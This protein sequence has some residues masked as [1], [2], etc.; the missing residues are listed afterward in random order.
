MGEKKTMGS[1]VRPAL[2]VLAALLPATATALDGLGAEQ[3][4]ALRS[5]LEGWIAARLGPSSALR[6]DLDGA[7]QVTAAGEG[8][9]VTLPPARL[10]LPGAAEADTQAEPGRRSIALD[11]IT[12]ELVPEAGGLWSVAW[13]LPET[14]AFTVDGS[15]RTIVTIE[16]QR[17]EGVY[18]AGLGTFIALDV[19]WHGVR[20]L[21][22][23]DSARGGSMDA[24]ALMV[25]LASTPHD[26]TDAAAPVRDAVLSATLRGFDFIDTG[27]ADAQPAASDR[28]QIGGMSV[29]LTAEALDIAA[30]FAL[31]ADP[32]LLGAAAPPMTGFE[33]AW[34]LDG[35]RQSETPGGVDGSA[36]TGT[37]GDTGLVID[38]ARFAV[39]IESREEGDG[40]A[41]F[42][43]GFSGIDNMGTLGADG[44]LIPTM[45]DLDMT[46]DGVPGTLAGRAFRALFVA[47]GED[48][49]D[50][51]FDLILSAAYKAVAGGGGRLSI[52]R[53]LVDFERI[54][55]GLSVAGLL[56]GAT[57]SPIGFAGVLT[58]TLGGME[59]LFDAI[60]GAPTSED[61]AYIAALQLVGTQETDA[62]GRPARRY[63][64]VIDETSG[65]VT[66]NGVA[67]DALLT[68]Q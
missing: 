30:A 6:L 5:T 39:G 15:P 18:A 2:V 34:T 50:E 67:L 21:P 17:G 56:R 19:A 27:P 66:L 60:Q 37:E 58:V 7:M 44:G 41:R 63:E 1:R 28:T 31:L 54:D 4:A 12:I 13:T 23:P 43:L 26:G 14:F 20:A 3:A 9:V 36:A 25:A 40:A 59:A 35:F 52:E 64:I 29:T 49:L 33:V 47:A 8:Y 51:A 62:F 16:D 10:V 32:A 55:A 42:R 68:G 65:G 24:E 22:G 45:V 38:E 46:V 48:A 61:D 11:G 53:L 57:V